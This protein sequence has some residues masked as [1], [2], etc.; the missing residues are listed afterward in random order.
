VSDPVAIVA[1]GYDAMADRFAAWQEQISGPAGVDRVERLLPLLPVVPDVLELG[2]GA[3][4]EASQLLAR[5]ARLTGVDASAEQ[6]RRARARLPGATL[7]HGD[8]LSAELAA[9][10]DAVVALYVLN[11]VPRAQ[12]PE[13][14]GRIAGWLRPGGY[15]LASF[16]ATDLPDWRG[17]WLG[18]EM[19]FSGYEPDVTRALVRAAGLELLEDEVETV[20]EPEGDV[21][22]LWVLARRGAA[23]AAGRA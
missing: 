21:Q 20:H 11:H 14:M 23:P 5:R 4:K 15:F 13:L 9:S 12:L 22:F 8:F 18:V 1:A 17:E 16:G 10:F 7:I 2:V 3:G 19:F 6:L